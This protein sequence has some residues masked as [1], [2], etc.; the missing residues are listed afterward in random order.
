MNKSENSQSSPNRF[1]INI[2]I[3]LS[4]L[5]F[6][7]FLFTHSNWFILILV[8][9]TIY[10]YFNKAKTKGEEDKRD[11]AT[12]VS[13]SLVLLLPVGLILMFLIY[14]FVVKVLPHIMSSF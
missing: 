5:G 1:L 9:A 14:L 8:P 10:L 6:L 4:V 12:I 3:F 7:G 2:S 13:Y 11:G